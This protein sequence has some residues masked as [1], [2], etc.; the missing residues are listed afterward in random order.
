MQRGVERQ[1]LIW[2][3]IAAIAIA[4]GIALIVTFSGNFPGLIAGAFG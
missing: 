1:V 3:I 2:M 4:V